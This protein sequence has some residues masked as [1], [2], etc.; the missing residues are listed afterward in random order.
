LWLGEEV[1][2]QQAKEK[3]EENKDHERTGIT[4]HHQSR[5]LSGVGT[6]LKGGVMRR[7]VERW[8]CE[9]RMRCYGLDEGNGLLGRTFSS[10]TR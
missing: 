6:P 2:Q 1:G 9:V 3:L 4:I 10:P 5:L 8:G 7:G